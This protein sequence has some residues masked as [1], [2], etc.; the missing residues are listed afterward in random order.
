MVFVSSI[1]YISI[2]DNKEDYELYVDGTPYNWIDEGQLLPDLPTGNVLS[3]FDPSDFRET[4][5]GGC[6]DEFANN[7][8]LEAN[9]DDGSCE[10]PD[11][12]NTTFLISAARSSHIFI[13]AI[14]DIVYAE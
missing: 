8:N 4:L 7:Y 11:W 3:D 2:V 5:I 12:E 14:F 6:T 1:K 10:Y 9:S 13:D